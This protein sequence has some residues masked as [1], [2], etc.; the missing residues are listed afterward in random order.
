MKK[1]IIFYSILLSFF[2]FAYEFRDEYSLKENQQNDFILDPNTYADNGNHFSFYNVVNLA[3]NS[4]M[5]FIVKTNY[6]DPNCGFSYP[7]L[8]EISSLN[9]NNGKIE[10]KHT[11]DNSGALLAIGEGEEDINDISGNK[12]TFK[13]NVSSKSS[14][15]TSLG[16]CPGIHGLTSSSTLMDFISK[17]G[18]DFI[19]IMALKNTNTKLY[20]ELSD[21]SIKDL[22]QFYLVDKHTDLIPFSFSLSKSNIQYLPKSEINPMYIKSYTPIIKKINIFDLSQK[23]KDEI[24]YKT[25]KLIKKNVDPD[26]NGGSSEYNYLYDYVFD[27]DIKNAV[28]N[29]NLSSISENKKNDFIMNLMGVP[30]SYGN[31]EKIYNGLFYIPHFISGLKVL[32][33]P[34][35]ND[36]CNDLKPLYKLHIDGL[37]EYNIPSRKGMWLKSTLG[38]DNGLYNTMQVGY[39]HKINNTL[40]GLSLAHRMNFSND[41]AKSTS[42]L[43][44]LNNTSKIGTFEL[45]PKVSF[46][47]GNTKFL[48]YNTLDLGIKGKYSKEFKLNNGFSLVPEGSLTYSTS[49]GQE[50]KIPNTYIS[51]KSDKI[52]SLIGE[53]GLKLM[54][55]GQYIKA[56]VLREFLGNT[57]YKF[58]DPR[59]E[60][61]VKLSNKDT[62][63]NLGIGGEY[64]IKDKAYLQYSL[65]KEFGNK[66]SNKFKF[67]LGVVF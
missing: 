53:L 56:S 3:P 64:S 61:T 27:N 26:G 21:K 34:I 58:T 37:D 4:K 12:I 2:A 51:F 42:I 67:N 20:L 38:L 48:K 47:S 16:L 14:E 59:D 66:L 44:Y 18:T 57:K 8:V 49:K 54:Y 13:I 65:E 43:G 25:V 23:E 6:N 63:F 1:L 7:S 32:Y 52:D 10:I 50:F 33:N 36:V 22:K 45:I 30:Y 17:K 28:D 15:I 5:N 31:S 62:W 41:K 24:I 29:N 35:I 19:T 40:V 11:L 60:T 39:N 9:S 46:V 55:K